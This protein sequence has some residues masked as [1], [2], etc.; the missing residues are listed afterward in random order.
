MDNLRAALAWSRDQG[1]AEPL[2]SMVTTLM[3]FWAWPGRVRELQMWLEAAADQAGDLSP[4]L[5]ARVRNWQCLIAVVV[6]GSASLGQV[7]ALASEALALARASGDK[8]EE[9]VAL[10][11]HGFL[12]GVVGGAEAMRPYLEEAR[13]L[14][15]SARSAGLG[16]I[17]ALVWCAESSSRVAAIC[18]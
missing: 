3:W 12:A 14:A 6:P 11:T 4:R 2:A 15:R 9:A 1:D 17:E 5:R 10:F 16:H 8:Y 18:A 7:P 13:L